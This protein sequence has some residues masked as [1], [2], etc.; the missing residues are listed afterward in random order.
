MFLSLK[1]VLL[2]MLATAS[3]R[4]LR[5]FLLL[6]RGSL[7]CHPLPLLLAQDSEKDASAITALY[8]DGGYL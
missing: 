3:A 7:P 6:H 4:P 2:A 5:M 8:S 1:L